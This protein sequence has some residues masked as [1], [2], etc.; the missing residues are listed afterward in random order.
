MTEMTPRRKRIR[1]SKWASLVSTPNRGY[2]EVILD[3]LR[4]GTVLYNIVIPQQDWF[5]RTRKLSKSDYA[6]LRMCKFLDY[7]RM[8]KTFSIRDPLVVGYLAKIGCK[9]TVV[10]DTTVPSTSLIS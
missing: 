4:R 9:P 1:A 7:D 2:A 5:L 8:T 6:I 3:G 10:R